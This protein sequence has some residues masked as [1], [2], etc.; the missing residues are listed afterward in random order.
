[1]TIFQDQL[2]VGGKF[3]Q[4]GA[5]SVNNI[6]MWDGSNWSALGGGIPGNYTVWGA[7]P[8]NGGLIAGGTS[9]TFKGFLSFW[10]GSSWTPMTPPGTDEPFWTVGLHA[11]LVFVNA[12]QGTASKLAWWDGSTWSSV[13]MPNYFTMLGMTTYHD[14]LYMIGDHY[15]ALYSWDGN[16]FGGPG[17][18]FEND[19]YELHV[20][21]ELLYLG[22]IWVQYE[23]PLGTEAAI[24][25]W[26][27][28]NWLPFPVYFYN[29]PNGLVS[30][31][32]MATYHGRLILG[33]DGGVTSFDGNALVP[34]ND[35]TMYVARDMRVFNGDLYVTGYFNQ[36]GP[37]NYSY[38]FA[39]WTEPATAVGGSPA[40]GLSVD[41]A[42]NP[43]NPSVAITVNVPAKG[44]TRVAI[45]DARGE[46]VRNIRNAV[47]EAGPLRLTW[48][49]TDQAGNRMSSGVYFVKAASGNQVVS[50]KLVLLK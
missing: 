29:Q 15:A 34:M 41:S 2:V 12:W 25:V 49:G 39:K 40:R 31:E 11:G 27:G 42:P 30:V 3:T 37:S 16:A 47:E 33:G 19:G 46:L 17:V 24:A 43:F 45:Y 26:D 22:G 32:A 35:G 20:Y 28:D 13:A 9:P 38:Y 14:Q 50:R 7:V 23:G 6:A 36:A 21:D 10:D 44:Q 5:V 8:Y 18:S 1:M 4:A 48:D